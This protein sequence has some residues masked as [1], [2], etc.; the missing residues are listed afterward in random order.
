M[1]SNRKTG[2]RSHPI[3]LSLSCPVSRFFHRIFSRSS[4]FFCNFSEALSNGRLSHGLRERNGGVNVRKERVLAVAEGGAKTKTSVGL[5]FKEEAKEIELCDIIRTRRAFKHSVFPPYLLSLLLQL[6]S[7]L[8]I[9]M[10]FG[11]LRVPSFVAVLG[12]RFQSFW[13]ID[14]QH[15]MWQREKKAS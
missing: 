15:V 6:Q 8:R 12:V 11:V 14:N 5:H 13:L 9:S 1:G 2:T 7:V 4:R 3:S 10:I